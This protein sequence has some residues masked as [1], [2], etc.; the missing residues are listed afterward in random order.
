M[1]VRAG[2]HVTA[3]QRATKVAVVDRCEVGSTM[4]GLQGDYFYSGRDIKTGVKLRLGT[5]RSVV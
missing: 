2:K 4:S 5:C 1:W 3:E